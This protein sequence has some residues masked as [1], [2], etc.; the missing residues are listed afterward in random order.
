VVESRTVT[1]AEPSGATLT[2]L[3]IEQIEDAK[4][5]QRRLIALAFLFGTADGHWGSLSKQALRDFRNAQGIGD[6]DTWNLETQQRLFSSTAHASVATNIPATTYL[7]GWGVS[8]E[9]CR[10]TPGSSPL[11]ISAQG[12]ASFG[13]TYASLLRHNR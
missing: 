5:I 8:L 4:R 7:G 1:P 11:Q 3:D 6:D 9:Q 2:L 13:V 12:A 10:Q